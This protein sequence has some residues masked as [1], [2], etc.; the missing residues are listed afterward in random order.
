MSLKN[1][2]KF[3]FF[4]QPSENDDFYLKN[5]DYSL[6]NSSNS[7]HYFVVIFNDFIFEENSQSMNQN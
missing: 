4:C 1:S 7:S 5:R 6:I 2:E 3:Y